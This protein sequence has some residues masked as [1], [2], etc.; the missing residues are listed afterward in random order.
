[1]HVPQKPVPACFRGKRSRRPNPVAGNSESLRIRLER[2]IRARIFS[3]QLAFTVFDLDGYRAARIF[4]KVIIDHCAVWRIFAGGFVRRQRRVRVQV[5]ANAQR[6]LRLEQ[7]IFALV[8]IELPERRD[9]VENS[10][11][12]TMRRDNEVVVFNDQIA[13]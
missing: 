12:A 1:M 13:H 2:L 11:P 10:E 6:S 4:G 5:R 8:P 9:V 3:D 7:Q